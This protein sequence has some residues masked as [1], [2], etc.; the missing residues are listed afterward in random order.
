MTNKLPHPQVHDREVQANFEFIEGQLSLFV[1]GDFAIAAE[2]K[3]TKAKKV[4]VRDQTGKLVGY[5][6]LY[7]E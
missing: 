2:V 7:A 3:G 1:L 5:I 4:A 6:P